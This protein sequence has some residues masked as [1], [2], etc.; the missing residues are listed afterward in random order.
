MNEAKRK[1]SH[2]PAPPARRTVITVGGTPTRVELD[3]WRLVVSRDRGASGE[4]PFNEAPR[5]PERK[6]AV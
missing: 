3:G 5:A 2:D 6:R 1:P 4:P